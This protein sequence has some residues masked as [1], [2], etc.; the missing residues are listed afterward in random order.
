MMIWLIFAVMTAAVVA[1]LLVPFMRKS[2]GP[3]SPDSDF[4]RAIYRDQLQELDRDA[5]RGPDRRGGGSGGPQ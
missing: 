5:A 2:E 1:A 3:Q 4:D